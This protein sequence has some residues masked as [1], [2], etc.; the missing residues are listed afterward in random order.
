MNTSRGAEKSH[1]LSSH[2][3]H[4]HHQYYHWK[5]MFLHCSTQPNPN[6]NCLSDSYPALVH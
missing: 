2:C 5:N 4:H 6:P 3:Y 1:G